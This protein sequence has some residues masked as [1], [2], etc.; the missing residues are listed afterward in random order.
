MGDPLGEATPGSVQQADPEKEV[1]AGRSV[2]TGQLKEV[3]KK[4]EIKVPTIVPGLTLGA[5]PMRSGFLI[6]LLKMRN[7]EMSLKIYLKWRD[8]IELGI[9]FF[10]SPHNQLHLSL[11]VLGTWYNV[12]SI[13]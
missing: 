1:A 4:L 10:L 11:L 13:I 2:E 9:A 12:C 3:V 5:S 6:E 7:A 8:K